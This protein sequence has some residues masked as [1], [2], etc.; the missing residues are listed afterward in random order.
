MVGQTLT[1]EMGNREPYGVFDGFLFIQTS[2][3]Y[4]DQDLLDLYTKAQLDAVL[5]PPNHA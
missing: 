1:F 3:I 5:Q 4:P 2:N